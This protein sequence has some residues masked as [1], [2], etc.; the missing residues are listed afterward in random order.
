[1]CDLHVVHSACECSIVMLGVT[2]LWCMVNAWWM[3]VVW[4]WC[5]VCECM[6]LDECG[7]VMRCAI[8]HVKCMNECDMW[9]WCDTCV[10][11]SMHWYIV[12]GRSRS[13]VCGMCAECVLYMWYDVWYTWWV[14]CGV[15]IMCYR[16]VCVI[17]VVDMVMC[18]EFCVK[19]CEYMCGIVMCEC[20]VCVLV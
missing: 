7:V 5:Y 4:V 2:W 18:G 14:I 11:H 20:I 15:W 13:D 19:K 10:C 6:R 12:C 3:C 17:C 8:W 9:M 1:M 16:W